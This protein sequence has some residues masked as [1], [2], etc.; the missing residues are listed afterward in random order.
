MLSAAD[1]RR[2]VQSA[3]V[4]AISDLHRRTAALGV[5]D[6]AMLE[7]WID[8]PVSVMRDLLA[9]RKAAIDYQRVLN[10]LSTALQGSLKGRRLPV[11]WTHG[12]FTPGN[13]LLSPDA[14]AVTG[15]LDW[16]QAT[17]QN[18]PQL[19]LALLFLSIRMLE[20]RRELGDV[21]RQML[22]A[23]EWSPHEDD[24]LNTANRPLPGNALAVREMVLLAWLRHIEANL[25]KPTH[26]QD[27]WFWVAKNI[28]SVL[29]AL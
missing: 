27:N 12:D 4:A 14:A 28:E 13:I 29:Q 15:I 6:A 10:R 17:P 3:A 16:D 21:V 18:L 23:D 9:N 5:V 26:Y 25:T 1:T 7:R 8:R 11:S 24:L 2:R 19:D 22:K 20:Q